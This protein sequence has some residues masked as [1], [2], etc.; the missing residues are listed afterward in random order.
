MIYTCTCNPSLDYY[1]SFDE[2]TP[3][4]TN[5][6]NFE[7]F[8][9]GGKGINVSIALDKLNI[10]SC[11]FGFLGGFTKE[12]YLSFLYKYQNIQP[13]FTTI[14][15]NTRIDIKLRTIPET[16]LNAVGPKISKE[17]FEKFRNRIEKLFPG[18]T[19]IVSG[20]IQ[21]EI[22]DD[23]IE[24]IKKV[25]KE[26]IDV[27]IDTNIKMIDACLD[28]N[29]KLIRIDDEDV[30]EDVLSYAKML[31]EKT[32]AVVLYYGS[33]GHCIF[34]GDKIYSSDELANINK[35]GFGIGDSMVA[36]YIYSTIRGANYLESIKYAL[37]T[38]KINLLN[39][40]NDYHSELNE[41]Y[42]K[43]EVNEI[44]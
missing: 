19:L 40:S 7:S 1:L 13:L 10:R 5:R 9:A 33:N 32:G 21:E 43:M 39:E 8:N 6:S 36:G 31:H 34:V 18:D 14:K 44:I 16:S 26:G 11:A 12:F 27:V 23:M 42:K 4:I 41:L 3:G 30:K 20:N 15:D 17:E 25:S 24:L 29:I 35:V 38:A 37:A 28:H 2:I 22:Q